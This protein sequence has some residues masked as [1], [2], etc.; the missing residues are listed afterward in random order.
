LLVGSLQDAAACLDGLM[1]GRLLGDGLLAQ[2]R[3]LTPLGFPTPGRP[4]VK[5]G[6]GLGLMGEADRSAPAVVG[7]TGGG[8]GSL[9]VVRSFPGAPRLAVA[10]AAPWESDAQGELEQI[11]LDLAAACLDRLQARA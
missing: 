8:P 5:A 11:A 3:T 9:I 7:H 2:M 1:A 6:Y 4:V 10:V